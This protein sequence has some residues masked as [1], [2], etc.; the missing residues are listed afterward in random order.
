MLGN[1]K[2]LEKVKEWGC[3]VKNFR[4]VMEAT[5]TVEEDMS[6]MKKVRNLQLLAL[7]QVHTC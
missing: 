7:S 6:N 1:P 5:F 3:T 2:D 4:A